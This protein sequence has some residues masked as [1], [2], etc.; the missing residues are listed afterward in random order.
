M[1]MGDSYK[2]H[3]FAELA[4]VS[5][6]ALRHYERLGLLKTRRTRSGHRR[7]VQADLERIEA[8]TALK[9]L[10]FPLE[11]IRS[12]LLRPAAELPRAIASRRQALFEADMR[13]AVTRKAVAVADESADP[14]AVLHRIVEMVQTRVAAAAMRRYYTAEGW[15][16][17]RQYYEEGPSPEWRE[18]Y[19]TLSALVGQDPASAPVQA[20][21]DR[22]LA[23]SLRAYTGDPEVQTDSPTAW[24]DRDH[25]PSRLKRR[26]EEFNLE[27][28]NALVEQAAQAAPRKYFTAAAWD[29]YIARRDSRPGSVSRAWQ[30]RVTLFRDIEATLD[31]GTADRQAEAFRARWD[32]QLESASGGDAEIHEALLKMW[33]DREHWS[34]ALRWQVEAIHWMPY[35]RIQRVAEFLERPG[36]DGVD[37]GEVIEPRR[38]DERKS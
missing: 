8:I 15:Q 2:T 20:A 6:K 22:W 21:V 29:R 5:V 10:G 17:R 32:E 1:P 30:A 9:Y 14:E 11:Q 18:L 38:V 27:A 37:G 7:Y 4:G 16:R 28:V 23:L 19:G 26:I 33:A 36:A 25:W 35:A 34:A 12:I 3:D 13:I 31:S 24:A